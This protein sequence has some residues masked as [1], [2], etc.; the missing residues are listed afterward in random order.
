ML[1]LCSLI[2]F[3]Q[4]INVNLLDG[5][6]ADSKAKFLGLATLLNC[7]ISHVEKMH[8]TC[9]QTHAFSKA[10][11]EEALKQRQQIKD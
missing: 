3:F 4:A 8:Q 7:R 2:G 9:R 5:M 1:V 6:K 11:P 10:I